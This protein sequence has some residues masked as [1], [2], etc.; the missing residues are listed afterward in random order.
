M[1]KR[2]VFHWA[3]SQEQ[4]YGRGFV[5]SFLWDML[6]CIYEKQVY[7]DAQTDCQHESISQP[8]GGLPV[9]QLGR[10]ELVALVKKYSSRV[11]ALAAKLETQQDGVC[12]ASR[13]PP[14]PRGCTV[15]S[16]Y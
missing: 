1:A 10:D 8:N 9:E 16:H 11:K 3:A 12:V 4:S 5:S 6:L 14:P 15:P 7:Q 13:Q 2:A